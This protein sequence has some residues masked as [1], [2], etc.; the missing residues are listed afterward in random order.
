[1]N[2]V[3]DD[4]PSPSIKTDSKLGNGGFKPAYH[5]LTVM[6]GG[7][8]TLIAQPATWHRE[9]GGGAFPVL[10]G[11]APAN[12][13]GDKGGDNGNTQ[14]GGGP[15]AAQTTKQAPSSRPPT[16]QINAPT[17]TNT[18]RRP[19]Y[20]DYLGHATGKV[21]DD[22]SFNTLTAR[23]AGTYQG[24]SPAFVLDSSSV[25]CPIALL[26]LAFFGMAV[27]II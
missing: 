19:A 1:M 16:R 2:V 17:Y 23:P 22:S 26:P 24:G 6:K 12:E 7:A 14:S 5:G 20:S 9:N 4:N 10:I 21:V 27:L 15:T 3:N 8:Q 25:R 11:P 13:G 18:F